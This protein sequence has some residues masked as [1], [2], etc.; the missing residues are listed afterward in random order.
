MRTT[1]HKATVLSMLHAGRTVSMLTATH[2]NIG[3]L[4]EVIRRLR[5]DGYD[6]RTSFDFDGNGRR[7]CTYRLVRPGYARFAA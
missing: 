1:S 4:R 6:I 7:F 3:N 2:L 5:K